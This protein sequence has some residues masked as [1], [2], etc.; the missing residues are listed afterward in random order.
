MFYIFFALAGRYVPNKAAVAIDKRKAQKEK[1]EA[2]RL[3]KAATA[4]GARVEKEAQAAAAAEKKAEEVTRI[5]QRE[6]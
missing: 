4:D 1:E 5:K 2:A 3:A 6:G